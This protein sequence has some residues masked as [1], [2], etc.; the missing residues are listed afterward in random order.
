MIIFDS[1]V[2]PG[3]TRQNPCFDLL[4]AVKRSGTHHLGIPWMVREEICAQRVLEYK[5]AHARAATAIA[6]LNKRTPW[7]APDSASLSRLDVA[8]AYSYWR[9]QYEEL[10]EILETS[11]DAALTALYRESNCQRPAKVSTKEKGGARDVAI[12]LSVINYLKAHDDEPVIFVSGNTKDFGDGSSYASPMSEDLGTMSGRLTFLTSLDDFVGHCTD[13]IEIDIK[14]VKDI[15]IAKPATSVE[16]TAEKVLNDQRFAGTKIEAGEYEL[17]RWQSWL[18]PPSA[19]LRR[20]VHAWGHKIDDE[21]WYTAVVDWI[22]VGIA[23]SYPLD[24]MTA[25]L[26]ISQVWCEWRTKVLFSTREGEVPEIVDYEAPKALDP[27][28]QAELRPLIAEAMASPNEQA[29]QVGQALAA[30]AA[31]LAK[32]MPTLPGPHK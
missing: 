13:S 9:G 4:R 32:A 7:N 31:A 29:V 1:S 3:L 18:L 27:S 17:F 6:E 24:A 11:G 23:S 12:W 5:L 19:V 15:L 14:H 20:I 21:E 2:L 8:Q 30:F 16:I 26:T 25:D 22:M 10:F 28:D